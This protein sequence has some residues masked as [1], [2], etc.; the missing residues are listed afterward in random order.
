MLL[1]IAR[2]ETS[3]KGNSKQTQGNADKWSPLASW[4]RSASHS[5]RNQSTTQTIQMGSIGPSAIQPGPCAQRLPFI[6]LPV[7]TSWWKI[8]PRR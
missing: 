6:P 4:Q 2:I 8:I 3:S 5:A 1:H 7:V